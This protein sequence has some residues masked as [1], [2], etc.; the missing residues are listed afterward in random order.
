MAPMAIFD[1][2]SAVPQ[3]AWCRQQTTRRPEI[4]CRGRLRNTFVDASN[5]PHPLAPF[6][7]RDA[8]GQSI[9]PAP[10]TMEGRPLS[11]DPRQRRLVQG[12]TA[13]GDRELSKGPTVGH[14]HHDCGCHQCEPTRGHE[15]TRITSARA[16]T[17]TR[18]TD[19]DSR[20][21]LHRPINWKQP[22][23]LAQMPAGLRSSCTTSI[24]RAQST[25]EPSIAS[26][27]DAAEHSARLQMLG[28]RT[29]ALQVGRTRDKEAPP[30]PVRLCH[31]DPFPLQSAG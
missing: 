24:P 6:G 19:R 27:S 1:P 15:N 12:R 28:R 7:R 3:P 16:R 22:P 8:I 9:L 13:N 17:T 26:I 25:I 29:Y 21:P 10:Q 5:W 11:P 4:L 23:S 31:K 18:T 2:R 14:L 30:W 20:Q